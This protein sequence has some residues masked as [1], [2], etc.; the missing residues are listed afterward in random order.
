MFFYSSRILCRHGSKNKVMGKKML[1]FMNLISEIFCENGN[2]ADEYQTQEAYDKYLQNISY[3]VNDAEFTVSPVFTVIIDSKGRACASCVDSLKKQ[4]YSAWEAVIIGTD[5]IYSDPRIHTFNNSDLSQLCDVISGDFLCFA[6]SEDVL[7]ENAL[8]LTARAICESPDADAFYTD[9]DE[10][11]DGVRTAPVFKPVYSPDTLLSYNYIGKLFF[12]SK[13]LFTGCGGIKDLSAAGMYDY[14]LRACDSAAHVVHISA[15]LISSGKKGDAVKRDFAIRSLNTVLTE[16]GLNGYAVGGLWDGSFHTH[17]VM[18]KKYRCEIILYG[19]NSAD[20]LREWLELA[21]DVTCTETYGITVASH[22]TE[23][24]MLIRYENALMNNS[25]AKVMRFPS[26]VGFSSMCNECVSLTNAD[27]YIFISCDV[28]PLIPDWIDAMTEFAQRRDVGTVSPLI[29]TP[30]TRITEA[31]NV[32]GLQG[33]WGT[34]YYLENRKF[35]DARMNRFINTVRNISLGGM[36]CIMT[37][38]A[39]F[40]EL[41][42]FDESFT[43]RAAIAEYCIRASRKYRKNIYTPFSC[44]QGTPQQFTVPEQQD[45]QRTYDVLRP[46]LTQGDPYFSNAYNPAIFTPTVAEN[47]Y[48]GAKLNPMQYR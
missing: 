45:M 23:D 29:L 30:D 48:H 8:M 7:D 44:L 2:S 47:P 41:R 9:E 5:Y 11:K 10:I 19:A 26:S 15:V 16:K 34:P 3:S 4:T 6:N 24:T 1:E 27:V 12:T 40:T 46:Y 25:A 31:G 43:G 35:T 13:E 36:N 22:G 28:F 32:I 14:T 37:S 17:Y 18:P 38:G 21:E 42:G 20:K 33:W 39:V